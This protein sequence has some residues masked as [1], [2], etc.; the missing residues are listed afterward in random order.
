MARRTS[1]WITVQYPYKP[2]KIELRGINSGEKAIALA[3]E[4]HHTRPTATIEVLR[5]QRIAQVHRSYMT[6]R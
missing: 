5:V 1:Y 2:P 4:L 6:R 3:R